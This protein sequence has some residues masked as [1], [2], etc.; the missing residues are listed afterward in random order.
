MNSVT[1]HPYHVLNNNG[2]Q[3]VVL[4]T[5]LAAEIGP[6]GIWMLAEGKNGHLKIN[7]D[8]ETKP[9]SLPKFWQKV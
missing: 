6:E 4:L 9:A 2:S 3:T 5:V 7:R 8:V 1:W